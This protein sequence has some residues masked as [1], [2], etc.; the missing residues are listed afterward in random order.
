M[1]L[2]NIFA[3]DHRLLFTLHLLPFGFWLISSLKEK[4]QAGQ[5]RA[6]NPDPDS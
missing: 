1:G 2:G 4:V 6:G 5:G 3:P